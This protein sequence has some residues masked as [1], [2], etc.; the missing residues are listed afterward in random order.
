MKNLDRKSCKGYRR[1]SI[2]PV[3]YQEHISLPVP[4]STN[5]L[6]FPYQELRIS[7]IIICFTIFG[8]N[9]MIIHK[10]GFAYRRA[11]GNG[12]SLWICI[13]HHVTYHP[14]G[15][16]FRFFGIIVPEWSWPIDRDR[17]PEQTFIFPIRRSFRGPKQTDA[18]CQLSGMGLR[19]PTLY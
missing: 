5:S 10:I 19:Y 8:N 17:D 1:A 6:L 4:V 15:K 2:I 9:W 18:P 3:R 11:T 16:S 14:P 7:C 13:N 12:E